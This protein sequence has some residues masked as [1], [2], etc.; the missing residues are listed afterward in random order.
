MW[1]ALTFFATL[2]S[3][4]AAA[5]AKQAGVEASADASKYAAD[6]QREGLQYKKDAGISAWDEY[7]KAQ[8]K[9]DSVFGNTQDNLSSFYGSLT[10]TDLAATGLK[11]LSVAHNKSVEEMQ[12]NVAQRGISGAA[13]TEMESRMTMETERKKAETRAQA[14]FAL[15]SMQQGFLGMGMQSKPNAP[16]GYARKEEM[17]AS[18][19]IID[20]KAEQDRLAQA[21][22]DKAA[23][24]A[25]AKR[26]QQQ[27]GGD[28]TNWNDMPTHHWGND[29]D[30]NDTGYGSGGDMDDGG[31]SD[32]NDSDTG[33]Y[34]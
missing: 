32:D 29:N 8:T 27:S 15:A 23:A 26:R 25:A 34:Y 17:A 10:S 28:K 1:E 18:Q 24:D 19:K 33:G 4:Q 16:I 3:N 20:D 5:R 11:E 31:S 7:D 14:P 12:R 13:A 9:W 2:Y 21:A 6:V 30:S 22:R